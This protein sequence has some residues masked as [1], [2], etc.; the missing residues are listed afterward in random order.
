MKKIALKVAALCFLLSLMVLKGGYFFIAQATTNGHSQEDA[1]TWAK[2]QEGETFGQC[3]FLVKAYYEYLGQSTPYGNAYEYL[4]GSNQ[5]VP[6]GWTYQSYPQPGD[7]A[8]WDR[9]VWANPGWK[10]DEWGHVGIVIEIQGSNILTMESNIDGPKADYSNPD[11]RPISGVTKFIRPDFKSIPRKNVLSGVYVIHSAWD[12]NTCLDIQGDSKENNANIQLYQRVYNDVQ[13]FRIIKWNDDYYCIKS[14]HNGRW[15]DAKTPIGDNSNVKLYDT[16]EDDE[17]FWYFED[18]GDGYVYIKNKTG[19][20]LDVQGD[21]AVNGANIQLYHYVDSNSQKWRLEDVTNYY[22][23]DDGTY[24]IHSAINN[25]Y[26]FDISGNSTENRANIQLY[27]Q[28]NTTVQ[29]YQFIKK[30]KYYV[31]RSVYADKWLDIRTPIGN[32]SNVQL[33][34]SYGSAEE[35]WVLE[36]AGNGYVFIR[37]NADYYLDVQGDQAKNNANIQVYRFVGNNSQKWLLKNTE[38]IVTFN[39]NGGSGEPSA[40]TKVLGTELILSETIPI[41]DGFT[42]AAWN[43]EKDGSGVNYRAGDKYKLDEDVTLYAVWITPDFVLP[44]NLVMIDESAFEGCAF[45]YAMIQ[46]GTTAISGNA[47]AQCK[48]LK[49]IYIPE[50]VTEIDSCSFDGVTELTIHGVKGSYAETYA[51]KKGFA[52]IE[53]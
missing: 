4:D 5:H 15:L 19:Y 43:T 34:E 6:D 13:K 38:H 22:S 52:F 48:Q 8:V 46:P 47:F 7:I 9:Y 21:R 24:M 40:Q 29:L 30:G 35:Q 41:Y 45:T 28:E 39:A 2:R 26:V 12:D 33:W 44:D 20:Y 50:S 17:D 31:I 27:K 16:N 32:N 14:I 18:A 3:V 1:V 42:F 10:T 49:H 11:Y 37:S 36:D 25:D 51:R 23:L 53:G